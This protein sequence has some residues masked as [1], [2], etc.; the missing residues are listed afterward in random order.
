MTLRSMLGGILLLLTATA[1]AAQTELGAAHTASLRGVVADR[2]SHAPLGQ[3]RVRARNMADSSDVRE[4]VSGLDGAFVVSDL[5]LAAYRLE[6]GRLG[7]APLRRTVQIDRAAQTLDTLFLAVQAL[8]LP[9]VTV[10]GPPPA[11]AQ[12]ADTTEFAARAY[13]TSRDADASELLQK[14]PGI[15]VD[16]GGTIK[17]NGE[18]VRQILLDGRPYFGTD[19]TLA[20]RN[21]PAEVID[22]IQVFDKLSDQ[23]EF[24]G[25]DDGQA[26]RTINIVLRAD[27]R[28]RP[29]GKAYGGGGNDGRYLTGGNVNV[30]ADSLRYA[31]I[32]LDDNVN[33]QNFSS[34]DLLGVLNTGGQRG[35]AFGGGGL[36]RRAGGGGPRRGGDGGF[37][38]G[39]LGGFGG[40]FPGANPSQFLV[41]QQDGITTTRA[42]GGNQ[43]GTLG[44]RLT[45]SQSY[46][47]NAT[48]NANDQALVRQYVVPQ[49]SIARYDQQS[50]SGNHNLNHRYD[51]RAEWRVSP[52]TSLIATPRLYFQTNHAANALAGANRDALDDM[53][54][55]ATSTTAS[56]TSGHDLTDHLLVRHRFATRGRT[57]SVD[58][59]GG[60]NTKVGAS[61]QQSLA[62]FG[63]D[64][65]AVL[66]TL[67]QRTALNTRTASLSA[68]AVATEP[69]GGNGLLMLTYAPSYSDARSDNRAAQFD[70][71]TQDYTLPDTGLSNVFRSR[72]TTQAAHVGYLL[73]RGRTLN[74]SAN[75]G[76]QWTALRDA[77]AFPQSDQIARHYGALL[78]SLF[79]NL[80][81]AERRNLRISFQ[82]A[83][84]TPT[85]TQ[86][87]NVVDNSNPLQLTTGNPD[88]KPL[89]TR[90]LVARWSATT[91]ATSH[92]LFLLLSVQNTA[93]AIANATFT[94]TRDTLLRGGVLLPAGAQLVS[95]VNL[96]GTWTVN[97]FAT[98]SRSVKR[99]GSNVNV[100]GG[101]TYARTPGLFDGVGN[102]TSSWTGTG[103]VVLASNIS[104][105]VDFTLSYSGSV[106]VASNDVE[107]SLDQHEQ[108]H[109][110]GARLN[111]LGW[112]GVALRNDFSLEIVRGLAGGF[113]QNVALW[114][115]SLAKKLFKDD[116]GEIRLAANDLLHQN[117]START[118]SDN[119]VQDTRNEVLPPYVMLSVTWNLR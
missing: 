72:T 38:G 16:K 44:A 27:R 109:T 107:H 53:L 51:A 5:A 114:N 47:D 40:G 60:H 62:E 32:G 15:T 112:R 69:V 21:L 59:G 86:L 90:T 37:G 71:L 119:I 92:G 97:S 8:Q 28:D 85:V 116:R 84:S 76:Y 100:S 102:A 89:T 67:N 64:S 98:V 68:R 45:F 30:L 56:A 73:R 6:A 33:Q 24:T 29:F 87:Q 77:Q 10:Q 43:S 52:S 101:V 80:N 99:L 82:T 18:Q 83:V 93:H 57:F 48:T 50:T 39:G 7:Y 36:G 104:E 1:A 88:L 63:S 9:G 12:K 42:I 95:P 49:D 54:S 96:D 13:K 14:M 91:P 31:L 108:T 46:F 110:I 26:Q 79:A 111:L 20:I 70:P 61:T 113:D 106:N 41:G 35:G 75:L 66:D 103:G 117:R 17:S 11:V 22:K 74:V 94:A 3:V 105:A 115:A 55:S 118:V 65:S 4:V 81:S 78:P 19:P 2:R 34:Q 25:F 23:S 58:V